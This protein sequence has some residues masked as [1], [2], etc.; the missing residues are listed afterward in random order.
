MIKYS[1]L[2]LND[3]ADLLSGKADKSDWNFS[4]FSRRDVS[5]DE[6]DLLDKL[7]RGVAS[8]Y[9]LRSY[10]TLGLGDDV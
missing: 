1:L 3:E 9:S 5:R 7:F 4:L 2:L 6:A 10:L 8:R